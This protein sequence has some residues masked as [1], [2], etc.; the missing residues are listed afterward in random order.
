MVLFV[1]IT[2][3]VIAGKRSLRGKMPFINQ[4]Y[5]I[6]SFCHCE[7]PTGAWQSTRIDKRDN[8]GLSDVFQIILF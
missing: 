7:R 6:H 1:I 4:L 8:M 2:L 5:K 3:Y